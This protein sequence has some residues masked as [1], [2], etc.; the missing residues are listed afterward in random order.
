MVKS[1][2]GRIG[3]VKRISNQSLGNM[4]DEDI[5]YVPRSTITSEIVTLQNQIATQK[6]KVKT[7]NRLMEIFNQESDSDFAKRNYIRMN[8]KVVSE[9]FSEKVI[10]LYIE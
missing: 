2:C 6:K 5:V 7:L 3:G 9:C 10:F 4:S 1:K 8:V